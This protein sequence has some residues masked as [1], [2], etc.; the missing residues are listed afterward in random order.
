M[1]TNR[2]RFAPA[3]ECAPWSYCLLA[4]GSF[5]L[6]VSWSFL[7][8]NKWPPQMRRRTQ[9]VAG[10]RRPNDLPRGADW[11]PMS[12]RQSLAAARCWR[13]ERALHSILSASQLPPLGRL[14]SCSSERD[15]RLAPSGQPS[16][17]V[18]G[19]CDMAMARWQR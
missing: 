16:D 9:Q 6:A 3:N 11:P 19:V 18:S 1:E 12:G 8:L 13:A 7:L 4:C 17:L 15:R 14:S 2:I 5:C 10:D